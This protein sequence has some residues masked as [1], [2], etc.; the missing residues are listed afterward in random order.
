MERVARALCYSYGF[1]AAIVAE[2]DPA[3]WRRNRRKMMGI[4]ARHFRIPPSYWADRD[5]NELQE[6][7][8]DMLRLAEEERPAIQLEP[9]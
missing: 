5:V 6:W 8:A 9:G 2:V 1:D 4:L 3:R 7:F